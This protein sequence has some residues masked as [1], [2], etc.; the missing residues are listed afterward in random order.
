MRAE[1]V[2]TIA[3]LRAGK[4][5]GSICYQAPDE[6]APWGVSFICPCGCGNEGWLNFR[7]HDDPSGWE[8]DGNR[9]APTLSP[10]VLQSGMPCKW[11]GY[12]RG[13]EW[14]EC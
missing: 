1:N 13:G 9:E 14:V 7:R 10:S 12:L 11:H 4:V 5:A 6:G 8:W 3:E 2:A